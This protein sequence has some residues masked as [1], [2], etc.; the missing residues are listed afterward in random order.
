MG[1]EADYQELRDRFAAHGQEQ[2]FAY[3]NELSAAERETLLSD[4]RQVDFAWL[5]ARQAQLSAG[6]GGV[7]DSPLTPAPVI[8]L[9]RTDAEKRREREAREIG[10]QALREGKLAA[11]LVAGGQGTRLG[12]DGPKGCYAVG[13]VTK[14]TLFQWHADQILARAKRY[15]QTIPWYIMTSQLNHQ[16]TVE[17]FKQNQYL[18]FSPDDV[19]FFPQAMVPSFDQAGKLILAQRHQLA[20]NPDGHGGSLTALV[21]SG[22]IADMKR[23]GVTTI[24]YFQVD[25]PLVTICDPVFA[26]YHLQAKAEMSSKILD[27]TGPDEKVGH[28]CYQNGQLTVIEYSD[29]SEKDK[30]ARDASGRLVFWAGSIAIHMLDAAFVERIGG[31]AELPWHVAHKKIPFCQQG[32]VVTPEKPN[33]VKFETFVFDALPLTTASVTMEVNR[34]D[35]FAPVKNA[36]GVDSAE[37]CRQL[38]SNQFGRW[39]EEC[40]VKTPRNA[41][42]DVTIKIEISPRFALDAA[43]LKAKLPAKLDLSRDLVL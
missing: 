3:W 22:A 34:V 39:L 13:P 4:C 38:L 23:R 24:S 35:E 30:Q 14:R 28:I 17:Y 26:G 16:P 15:G 12:Y 6:G 2:V 19:K 41:A 11:F 37:S 5:E 21:R 20:L 33:G 27:K 9:P 18:G 32:K 36:T 40:G 43:E 8:V 29:L 7:D 10:E 31:R 1:V 42:G 25:N